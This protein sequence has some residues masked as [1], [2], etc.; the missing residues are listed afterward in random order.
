MIPKQLSSLKFCRIKRG[1]KAPFEKDWTNKLYSYEEISK[2][3][4][5]NYGVLCGQ[6]DLAVIDCDKDELSLMVSQMLPKTFSVRTGGG[7]MHFYY[8]IPELKKKEI[9]N[10]DG[11]HL[12]EIQS[13][14]TQVVGAGSIHPNGNEYEVVDNVGIE[15]ISLKDIDKTFKNFMK[16]GEREDVDEEEIEDYGKLIEEIVKVWKEGDR[17]EL[18]L[19]IS[20]YL[21]KEKRLGA[22][23]V[24]EI[25]KR[26][27]EITEDKEVEMRLRAVIETFKKDEK[28]IKGFTG[29]RKVD[30]KKVER[31]NIEKV[32]RSYINKEDLTNKILKVKP[33]FYDKSKMWWMW[34]DTEFKW[35]LV[36]ET[37][38][39]NLVNELS[40]ANT[41]NS[42]EKTEII[43]ALKQGGRLNKPK[44]IK[45][46]W[47]QFKNLIVNI[48]T[49][50]EFKATPEYFVTNPIPWNLN[51]ERFIE[52]PNMD[53]IFEE[54]VG[55]DY[56]K[57]LYEI[58]AYCLIPDYPIHRLFCFIGE[59]LNGKSKFLKLLTNFIGEDNVTSTELDTLLTSRFEI[60]RLHKKLVCQMGETNF[61]EI[62]KTSIIKK[63]T[64][65]D[66]IGFEYKNKNPFDS[67]N[68][69]KIMI[70]TNN[71]PTTTDK[72]VG[73]YRRWCIIDFPNKFSEEKDI[74]KDI[75]KEEYEILAVKSLMV[76]KE[77]MENRKFHNE[78]T[79]E[80]RERKYE[81]KS[82]PL[83][84]FMKEFTN[85]ENPDGN[86]TKWE[87]EKVLNEWLKE[88]RFRAMSDRTIA[89]RMKEKN[90]E[91][92]RVYVDFWEDEQFKKK[93]IRAWLGIK[94]IGDNKT[95]KTH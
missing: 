30:L 15:T 66:I 89:K 13:Y 10:L 78:G 31:D 12:G 71:L 46:T 84:K 23:K 73:F 83:E 5:E 1:N 22:N 6:K 26:V 90:V 94:W 58:L 33:I 64:G 51:K 19:S 24:K 95:D 37:D 65:Q 8:F 17:Q 75:P 92:G 20:G 41:I 47:I 55:K 49:G 76:L 85:D 80:E 91:D 67:F 86:I 81:E 68:Y 59:G 42:K 25:I 3:E 69:A 88:N 29:L 34:R 77:L 32:I 79:I 36:D 43:E 14:G 35:E 63:L 53:K 93:Q 7:G 50:K 56:V 57:T 4:N 27:C 45:P 39:L 60:T 74:L 54:W 72:T 11:E 70:A 2:F 82:D 21:R 52:T 61:S 9:L 28:D 16:K 62:N 87:F 40:F 48:E 38:V 44:D 18:A